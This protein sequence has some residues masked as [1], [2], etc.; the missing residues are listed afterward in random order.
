M[1]YRL[2]KEAADAIIRYHG[3]KSEQNKKDAEEKL[4]TL[5][6]TLRPNGMDR[7]TIKMVLDDVIQERIAHGKVRI[8]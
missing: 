1:M 5:E 2:F 4:R 7:Y 8:S 3:D 6:R